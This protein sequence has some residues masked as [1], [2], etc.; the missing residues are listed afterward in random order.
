[1]AYLA[2]PWLVSGPVAPGGAGDPPRGDELPSSDLASV[3]APVLERALSFLAA[4]QQPDGGWMGFQKSD[5]AITALVAKCF[6]QSPRHGPRHPIAQRALELVL[7]YAKQDGGIY[8][9]GQGLRNYQTSV[10]LMALAATNDAQYRRQIRAAQEFLT[11]LQWDEGEGYERSSPWY[12]GAGYGRQ[13][14]PDLSNTQMM[15]EALAQ[16]GL[17]PEH[18]TY[19]K[20]VAFISRCQMLSLTNDQPFAAGSTEGGFVYTP[21]NEGE[22]K[23]G[24]VTVEGRPRLRTY[25]SMTYAGFKSLLH[26]R[27]DRND[28][29]VQRAVDWIRRYYT[30]DSNPNM[31]GV[32]SQEGLY[33]Y[34][35]VFAKALQAWG[36]D[37]IT[38]AAG[39]PH[40]WREELCLQF[41]KRQRE[42]GSFVNAADR[43]MEGNPFLVTAYVILA[44]QTVAGP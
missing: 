28:V 21:A 5:P 39:R 14:R 40:R 19:E 3:T 11:G 31:P 41:K 12:G 37:E 35:Y 44:V 23:A 34:Y 29:R 26:A 20:A 33:Y 42:D 32:Q 36:E 4:N 7:S 8:V 6:I 17:P 27:V 15:L 22:S 24:T 38:D 1:V 25:G 2:F 18:P 30:L 43:W 9:E 16:S 10:C 13:K